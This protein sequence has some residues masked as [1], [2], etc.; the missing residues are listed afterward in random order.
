MDNPFLW[1]IY[2]KRC[3]NWVAH[4]SVLATWICVFHWIM[5][6]QNAFSI[7]LLYTH[8]SNISNKSIYFNPIR[9]RNIWHKLQWKRIQRSE[10]RV[11]HSQQA[12]VACCDTYPST[13]LFFPFQSPFVL[14]LK[15]LKCTMKSATFYWFDDFLRSQNKWELKL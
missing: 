12:C 10:W 4:K 9:I 13:V 2:T 7:F 8:P 11:H 3:S 1:S 14:Q 15:W 5:M 6:I